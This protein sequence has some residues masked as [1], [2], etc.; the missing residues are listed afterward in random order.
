M[1]GLWVAGIFAGGVAVASANVATFD[2]FAEGTFGQ[3][4]TDAGILF[5]HLD[6]YLGNGPIDNFTIE[7]ASG[8]LAG[9]VNFTSPNA[10]G[11]GGYSPG[12]GA[13]F[14]RLGSFD[15]G[16]GG[17]ASFASFDFYSFANDPNMTIT[18]Q[19]L[20][21]GN[22]VNSATVNV[23][24]SFSIQHT[25]VA[26]PSGNYD[27]FHVISAGP[28]NQGATFVLLDNVTVNPVPEPASLC[29]LALGGLALLRRRR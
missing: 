16:I 9:Q 8:D 2:S 7:N 5:Q 23:P 14:T 25:L 21:A 28:T 1:K 11:F 27:G 3:T 24:S 20:L 15:F 29:V 13:A 10:L 18:L 26:L 19:G 22:V 6:M 12:S 4:I 17:A